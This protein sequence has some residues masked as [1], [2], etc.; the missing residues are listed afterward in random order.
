MKLVKHFDRGYGHAKRVNDY[1]HVWFFDDYCTPVMFH[2]NA[3]HHKILHIL[4]D[5][6]DYD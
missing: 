5:E 3:H 2:W 6:V 4:T 1:W